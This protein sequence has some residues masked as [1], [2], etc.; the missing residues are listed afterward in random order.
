MQAK[1]LKIEL[2]ENKQSLI[3][4]SSSIYFTMIL[5]F[6]MVLLSQYKD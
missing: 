3:K 6:D 2:W 1:R 4:H 5:N